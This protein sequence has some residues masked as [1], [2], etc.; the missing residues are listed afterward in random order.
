M[1]ILP[2]RRNSRPY[3]LPFISNETKPVDHPTLKGEKP[4]YRATKKNHKKLKSSI[5]APIVPKQF[6]FN[7]T[8]DAPDK[9]QCGCEYSVHINF[10]LS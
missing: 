2:E 10:L 5:L 7:D 3:L 8:C 9:S 4:D 6:V 1:T